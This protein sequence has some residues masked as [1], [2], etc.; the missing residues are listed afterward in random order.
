FTKRDLLPYVAASFPEGTTS[1]ALASAVDRVLEAAVA[2]GE[3]I[4]LADPTPG[5]R[6]WLSDDALFTTRTQLDRE[7]AV[8][9]AV[10]L[11]STVRLDVEVLDRAAKLRELTTQQQSAIRRLA[12]LDGRV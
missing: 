10:R 2:R 1:A 3:A 7:R 5:G 9:S 6:W 4:P 8:F 12:D 11:P